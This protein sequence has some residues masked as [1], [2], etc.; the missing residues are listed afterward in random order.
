MVSINIDLQT[1]LTMVSVILSPLHVIRKLDAGDLYLVR[2]EHS[3]EVVEG[4]F[5]RAEQ[6]WV[7]QELDGKCQ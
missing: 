3:Q 7:A 1:S 6:P 2:C 5:E 4:V